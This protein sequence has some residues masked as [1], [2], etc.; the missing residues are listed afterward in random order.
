MRLSKRRG[1]CLSNAGYF[2]PTFN[3][4]SNKDK[5]LDFFFFQKCGTSRGRFYL[6]WQSFKLIFLD[7]KKF[8]EKYLEHQDLGFRS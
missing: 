5:L 2:L 3:G 6:I 4:V 8:I 7:I 1:C